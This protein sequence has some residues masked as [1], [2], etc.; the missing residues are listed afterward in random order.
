MA[1]VRF[2]L[3]VRLPQR[4]TAESGAASCSSGSDQMGALDFV[5]RLFSLTNLKAIPRDSGLSKIP[6]LEQA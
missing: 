6:I 4:P 5:V 1:S 3:Y 2:L